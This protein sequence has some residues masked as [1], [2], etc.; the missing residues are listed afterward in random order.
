MNWQSIPNRGALIVFAA[1]CLA[2][3]VGRAVYYSAGRRES[4]IFAMLFYFG[5]AG[6]VGHWITADSR[7]IG[8][9]RD[10]DGGF[11]HWAWP[12]AFPWHVFKTRGVQGFKTLGGFVA[13]FFG[14]CGVG[15]AVFYSLRYAHKHPL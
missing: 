10:P 15:L 13:I 4:D 11:S 14:A 9:R 2:G 3:N 1:M 5:F 8:L 6:A 12:I 7:R